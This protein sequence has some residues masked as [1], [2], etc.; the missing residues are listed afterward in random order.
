MPETPYEDWMDTFDLVKALTTF[1]DQSIEAAV[2][3]ETVSNLEKK[4]KAYIKATGE[5]VEV[6]GVELRFSKGYPVTR[7][8]QKQLKDDARNNKE[9]QRYVYEDEVSPGLRI[10]VE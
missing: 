4:C 8:Y 1:R 6:E 9:L 3:L 10:I 2:Y 7:V 5:V